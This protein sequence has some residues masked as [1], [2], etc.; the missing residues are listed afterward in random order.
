[1]STSDQPESQVQLN[2][3]MDRF[4]KPQSLRKIIIHRLQLKIGNIGL[5]H[6]RIS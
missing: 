4:L 2:T 5:G 3:G 1:M 6:L